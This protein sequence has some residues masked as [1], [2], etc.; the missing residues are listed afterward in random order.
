ML[1]LKRRITYCQDH[2]IK[3]N[4]TDENDDKNNNNRIVYVTQG[5]SFLQYF[6]QFLLSTGCVFNWNRHTK[7]SNTNT[8]FEPSSSSKAAA[9]SK[10]EISSSSTT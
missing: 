5:P 6:F 9:E 10:W 7:L 4:E 2:Q 8:K 1:H 3:K